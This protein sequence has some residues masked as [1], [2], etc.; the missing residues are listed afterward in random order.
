MYTITSFNS[1]FCLSL[2][3]PSLYEFD[4]TKGYPEPTPDRW[5]LFK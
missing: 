3:V 4:Y 2:F 1:L 5:I